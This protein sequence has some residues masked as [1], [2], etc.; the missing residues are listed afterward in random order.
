MEVSEEMEGP[1]AFKLRELPIGGGPWRRRIK[2]K[3]D[4]QTK[5]QSLK[6]CGSCRKGTHKKGKMT[7]IN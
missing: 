7:H 1:L 4:N 6:N 2:L 3:L 5:R